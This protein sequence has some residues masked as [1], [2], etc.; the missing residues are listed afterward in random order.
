M[1]FYSRESDLIAA[2]SHLTIEQV[3]QG[4]EN[5]PNFPSSQLQE[6]IWDTFIKYIPTKSQLSDWTLTLIIRLYPEPYGPIAELLRKGLVYDPDKEREMRLNLLDIIA[7]LSRQRYIIG[8]ARYRT[9]DWYLEGF[10]HNFIFRQYGTYLENINKIVEDLNRLVERYSNARQFSP[11]IRENYSSLLPQEKKYAEY[12][13]DNY[14]TISD[15]EINEILLKFP[16]C[17]NYDLFLQ[18]YPRTQSL[19]EIIRENLI[20][21]KENS[22]PYNIYLLSILQKDP[23]TEEVEYIKYLTTVGEG[24]ENQ[25][26]GLQEILSRL[27][28]QKS[29]ND[30]FYH[31]YFGSVMKEI[32]NHLQRIDPIVSYK[33]IV[34]FLYGCLTQPIPLGPRKRG[35]E[36]EFLYQERK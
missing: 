12:I 7:F 8:H 35:R 23:I 20:D 31:E 2:I 5:L 24:A 14:E 21:Y 30:L 26:K 29:S 13:A 33:K 25:M 36:G 32:L 19:E 15:E 28:I 10:V 11:I 22:S 4:L 6:I 18:V 27:E 1:D 3:I 17:Y 34:D 9:M 16:K